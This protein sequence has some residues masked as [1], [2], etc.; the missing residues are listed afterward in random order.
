MKYLLDVHALLAWAHQGSPHFTPFHRWKKNIARGDLATC[1]ITELGFV[2]VS[3]VTF[4]LDLLSA[5]S[6]LALLKKE[7]GH[8][9]P[10]LPS[11]IYP[12]WVTNH[13]HTT[14][15]YLCQVAAVHGL[16]LATFDRAIRDRHALLIS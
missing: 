9:I 12:S 3:L 2:R 1:A 11:P 7:I 5:V 10:D 13:R 16:K 8:F 15:A 6:T 14:D 4:E